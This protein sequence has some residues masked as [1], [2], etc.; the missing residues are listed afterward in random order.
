MLLNYVIVF[1]LELKTSNIVK[2]KGGTLCR[3]FF[4]FVKAKDANKLQLTL[5]LSQLNLL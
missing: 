2:P 5:T 3:W 4:K 1:G